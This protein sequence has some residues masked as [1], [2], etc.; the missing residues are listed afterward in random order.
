MQAQQRQIRDYLKAAEAR[1]NETQ[2]KIEEENQRLADLSGGSYTRKQEQ[3]ERAKAEAAH[4][5][6]QYE[7]HQRNTDRL[8]R[9]LEVAGKEVDSLAAPLGRT[10]ADVEQAEKLLR[11]LSKEGGPKSSGFHDKMPSLLRAVQQE[12]GFTE[13]PVGP[14]GRH[15]T[16]LKPE[17]SSILENSFGTTLNSFIVTSKRDMDILSRVMHNVNWYV[18]TFLGFRGFTEQAFLTMLEAYAQYL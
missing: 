3:L 2:Q 13:R 10:K 18:A 1:I 15:V 16:L 5:S 9:E 17:W 6:A 12:Q 8:Y 7:E 4:A 11:S 14:I